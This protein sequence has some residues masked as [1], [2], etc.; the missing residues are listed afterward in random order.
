MTLKQNNI[1][2][3]WG[4]ILIATIVYLI[5]GSF[6]IS[7]LIAIIAVPYRKNL[8]SDETL[9]TVIKESPTLCSICLL[10][11][12]V[13]LARIY[14]IMREASDHSAVVYGDVLLVISPLL[15][16]Y[17]LRDIRSFKNFK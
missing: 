3:N 5:S 14:F 16:L 10:L 11:V 4:L 17:V 6:V 2:I 8:Y 9:G 15:L 1:L 7:F 12:L 13:F